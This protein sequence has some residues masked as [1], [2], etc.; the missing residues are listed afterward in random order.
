MTFI[1]DHS[2][3]DTTGRKVAQFSIANRNKICISFKAA[4]ELKIRLFEAADKAGVTTSEFI[5]TLLHGFKDFQTFNKTALPV[6]IEKLTEENRQ[7]KSRIDF[8]EQ[9]KLVKVLADNKGKNFRFTDVDG[10][11][12]DI[13]VDTIKDAF[14]LLIRSFKSRPE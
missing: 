10:N 1:P 2:L 6:D 12:S 4:P 14:T 13:T 11:F 3:V 9:S 8:Y 5:E 7:L